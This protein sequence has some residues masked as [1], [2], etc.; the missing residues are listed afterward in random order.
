MAQQ[1]TEDMLVRQAKAVLDFT[2]T[3]EYTMPGL[4]LYPHQ[5]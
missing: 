1:R 4:R 5:W 3:G 2:W